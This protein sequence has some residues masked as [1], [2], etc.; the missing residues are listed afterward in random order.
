MFTIKE[1]WFYTVDEI[2]AALRVHPKTIWSRVKRGAMPPLHGIGRKKGYS[3]D[4][5]LKLIQGKSD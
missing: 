2:A 5:L 3:G 4:V 1:D